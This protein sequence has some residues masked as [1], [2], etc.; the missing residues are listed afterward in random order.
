MMNAASTPPAEKRP[1]RKADSAA[2]TAAPAARPAP[3]EPSVAKPAPAEPVRPA[4]DLSALIDVV[5]H[6]PR[7]APAMAAAGGLGAKAQAAARRHGALAAGIAALLLLG[8][9]AAMA[10][11]PGQP[12]VS[13]DAV[14]ALAREQAQ[15]TKALNETVDRL[16][17]KVEAMAS[18]IQ[19]PR[20]TPDVKAL[21]TSVEK[22]EAGLDK[23]RNEVSAAL[24]P[25]VGRFE[26]IDRR[27]REAGDRLGQIAERLEKLEK[28][29]ATGSLAPQPQPAAPAPAPAAPPQKAAETEPQVKGWTLVEVSRGVALLENGRNGLY[30]VERGANVPGL[31]RVQAIEK[32][33]TGWVVVTS[34]GII[35]AR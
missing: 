25:L 5:K 32:R 9:G 7:A 22:L 12:S 15:A 23:S 35:T 28:L 31:G 27:Q 16:S 29:G 24:A 20:E 34:Q 14:A 26:Q 19:R 21:K 3:A 30:E 8:G 6:T 13:P 18:A 17:I 1:R 33:Q 2:M 4:P 10:L 11:R